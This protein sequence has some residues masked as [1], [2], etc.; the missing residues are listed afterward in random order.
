MLFGL[1]AL[2]L[3]G[4]PSASAAEVRLDRVVD[5]ADWQR[6]IAFTGVARLPGTER[7]AV[8][9]RR[10]GERVFV[11][12]HGGDG[13]L[14]AADLLA[15]PT[16]SG[17][18]DVLFLVMS[19]LAELP[20]GGE[21]R[22]GVGTDVR[23]ASVTESAVAEPAVAEPAVAE[24]AVAQGGAPRRATAPVERAALE[25][26]GDP[27]AVQAAVA[28]APAVETPAVEPA[29]AADGPV[30]ES[31]AD[32]APDGAAARVP[33][34]AS[35]SRAEVPS[36]AELPPVNRVAGGPWGTA[37]AGPS[38]RAGLTAT[39]QL[40]LSGG[41]APL[42]ALRVGLATGLTAPVRPGGTEISRPTWEVP[43]VVVVGWAPEAEVAPRMLA[44]GGT[45]LRWFLQEGVLEA[46]RAV[47]VA[48]A[49]L[50]AAFAVSRSARITAAGVVDVD[51]AQVVTI[52]GGVEVPW[53]R[54][55]AG[56]RV[57][58]EF[59]PARK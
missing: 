48:G 12:V 55:A 57:G 25:G 44:S 8:T 22:G 41:W 53:S 17:R 4:S 20:A 50:G 45:S 1:L 40:R 46:T 28:Q 10:D 31:V 43:V 47:P 15:P 32:A 21:E 13:V 42:R 29:G 37:T 54:V 30:A 26:E 56:V 33:V 11:E 2:L 49:S 36:L 19:L 58:V 35:A 34:E 5:H 38:F 18:D 39:G 52:V 9:L 27:P 23:V 59:G 24:P 51:L 14:R 3:T 16:P 6:A 7:Y